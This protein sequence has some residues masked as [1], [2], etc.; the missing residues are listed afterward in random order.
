MRRQ[1][2]DEALH[3]LNLAE[4]ALNRREW[5]A[6]NSQVR[7]CLESLFASVARIRLRG[8]KTRGQARK[9]L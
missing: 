5:E 2:L 9:E 7:A 3:H 6:A 1:G 4:G 8:S